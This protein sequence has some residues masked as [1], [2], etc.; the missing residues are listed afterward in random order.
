MCLAGSS[1]DCNRLMVWDV[2]LGVGVKLRLGLVPVHM[3][4]WSPDGN[5]LF[6]G[7]SAVVARAVVRV[8]ALCSSASRRRLAPA[9][10]ALLYALDHFACVMHITSGQLVL[11]M[12]A[13]AFLMG[14]KATPLRLLTKKNSTEA[15]SPCVRGVT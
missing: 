1:I 12:P 13:C 11:F 6:A 4:S 7:W 15:A 14:Q 9:R 3:L 10:K 8:Y 5:Y 2:A